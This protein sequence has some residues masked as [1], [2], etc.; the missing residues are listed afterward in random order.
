MS[1]FQIEAIEGI[2][3]GE[4][5][6]LSTHTGNGKTLVAD[7]AINDCFQKGL[8]VVYT[9]PIKALSN[10]KYNEF[11]REYGEENVGLVT[12]DRVINEDA[13]ILVVTTEVLRN[14]IHEDHERV[15]EIKYIILDEIHYINNEDRGTV[16]EEVIIFKH[17]GT[18]IIGLSATIP[19]IQDFSDWISSIHQEKVRKVYYPERI[20]K[21]KHYYFDKKLKKALYKDVIKNYL[22]IKN[23][24]NGGIYKN[25]HIDFI[26]YAVESGIL[27]VLCFVFSRKQCEEKAIELSSKLNL[28]DDDEKQSIEELVEDY[29]KKFTDLEKS[30]SWDKLKSAIKNGVGFHHAGLLPIIKQFM[31]DLFDM[32]LCKV[33]YA[34]ETFAVG[35]NYPVKTVFFDSL[36]KY[37]GRSFRNL[38][39]SEY[40]QM[41]GRA[42][43][44]GI[45]TFG[46]VFT[47]ADYKSVEYGDFLNVENL[48]AEPV[49]SQ[50]NLSYNVVLN[51]V[52]RYKDEEIK[53]FFNKSFA[54][55]QYKAQMKEIARKIKVL[56]K[57]YKGPNHGE[58]LEGCPVKDID[59][60][61]I[62]FNKNKKKLEVYQSMLTRNRIGP[63]DKVFIEKK[64][65]R[66]K[67]KLAKKPVKCSRNKKRSCYKKYEEI[68]K[69]K[70]S[71]ARRKQ[72][73]SRLKNDQPQ[74]RFQKDY[75]R[76]LSLLKS[77]N[78]L[79]EGNKLLP[80][81][82]VCSQIHIQELL[83]TELLFSGF[84]HDNS[85]D[86]INGVL[87]G[88]V[89]EDHNLAN[90]GRFY[91]FSF[92]NNQI[93]SIIE[94][95]NKLEI[96]HGLE[97]STNFAGN[98]CGAI[99][100]WSSGKDFFEIVKETGIPEGDFVN[101]CR[102]V[103]DLLRQIKGACVD[104]M[105]LK[106]KINNCLSKIDRG[107]VVLGL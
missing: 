59:R 91:S 36:R 23:S 107:V 53:T 30:S 47:L 32:K 29:E 52:R 19:N 2:L 66:L 94:K 72:Q 92:D 93:Y 103:S 74:M 22:S 35:I 33:L 106:K 37:D 31:E 90:M 13:N 88:I 17:E 69:Q 62:F 70:S 85:D 49:K 44:R 76:K 7:Y 51:L 100:A 105:V 45:D 80:R 65:A 78:Y 40:L 96:A 99:E 82:K 10:Q 67:E 63:K 61:P 25:F 54:N 8:K 57:K 26:E 21:Q 68:D 11:I 41:A 58:Y 87:A 56:D 4:N 64:A 104:D 42:G 39:G 98:I 77:F 5:V 14:M 79:D 97:A 60:C 20:V 34:T 28:L 24:S 75:E 16:W 55:Y 84:F 102:R 73:L 48:K 9:A 3:K 81:G 12:G 43:R 101:L 15:K 27:P 50:F 46:L 95:I 89:C 71:L 18:K 1:Q 83:V 86:V 6:I 38:Y